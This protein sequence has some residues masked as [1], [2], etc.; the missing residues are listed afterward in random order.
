MFGLC[1]A[2][3]GIIDR[4][5]SPIITLLYITPVS[6]CFGTYMPSSGSILYP[7]VCAQLDKVTH[8]TTTPGAHRPPTFTVDDYNITISAFQVTRKDKGRSMKMAC[9]CRNM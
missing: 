9:K 1:I 2:C 7:Y 4:H 6:T 3:L 5:Y 8:Q